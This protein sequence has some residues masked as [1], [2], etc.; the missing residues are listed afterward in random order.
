MC[1]GKF[2]VLLLAFIPVKSQPV[3]P[4]ICFSFL[5]CVWRPETKTLQ[6]FPLQQG[7]NLWLFYTRQVFVCEND[8][9]TITE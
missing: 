3:Y 7:L 5:S 9:L 2:L 6:H 1:G 4:Q 8:K